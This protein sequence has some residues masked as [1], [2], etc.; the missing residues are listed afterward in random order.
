[1]STAK[2]VQPIN[3][4]VQPTPPDVSVVELMKT[5]RAR[6]QADA[7]QHRDQRVSFNPYKA[8]HDSAPQAKAGDLL[9][10]EELRFLNER[11]AFATIARGSVDA[12]ASH[13][14]G[15]LG[16]LIVK[17]KRKIA[18]SIWDSILKPYFDQEKEFNANLVR[19]LNSASK[20][21]DHRD[22]ANFWELIRKIDV[23]ITNALDRIERIAD[24]GQASL[25]GNEQTIRRELDA[26]AK[27]ISLLRTELS[28]FH[29]ELEVVDRVSKGLE[30]IV[31]RGVNSQPTAPQSDTV[32]IDTSYL[33]LENRFR[34]SEEEISNRVAIYPEYFKEISAQTNKPVLEIGGGRGELQILFK[35]AGI[36]SYSVDIDAAMVAAGIEKGASILHGDAI[37]HLRT[38][39]DASLAGIIAVQVVEHLSQIQLQELFSL[40][41]KK[42]V[43]GGKIIFETINPRSVMAL[44]SNYFRDPTHVWPLHPD[45]LSF[46]MNLY[47]LTHIETRFL[48]PVPIE[49]GIAPIE[50]GAHMTPLWQETL[51]HINRNFSRLHELL[52]GYQDYCVVAE[53]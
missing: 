35:K 36:Q 1:M 20:Y 18:V 12:I 43:R 14:G 49:A 28:G 11:W 24:E 47:G 16:K 51:I 53:A 7:E 19:F 8:N 3:E 41:K 38:V 17:I 32:T 33:I 46:Q 37:A 44:S 30:A 10:S 52:Y 23:D 48:S 5:I 27:N 15:F 34:G 31:A 50:L 13:R 9:Y 40:A 6:V 39:A 26:T 45:T 21:I 2:N 25:R 42:V 22:A 4:S 29:Q